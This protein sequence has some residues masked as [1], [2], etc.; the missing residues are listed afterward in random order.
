MTKSDFRKIQ[1]LKSIRK[2]DFKK[3]LAYNFQIYKEIENLRFSSPPRPYARKSSPRIGL[4][5]HRC[6]PHMLICEQA[7]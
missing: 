2:S 7:I 4:I 3:S 6:L 1:P 5:V